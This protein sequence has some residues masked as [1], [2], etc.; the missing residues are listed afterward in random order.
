M[1][2]KFPIRILFF[3]S[4]MCGLTVYGQNGDISRFTDINGEHIISA[5]HRK[6]EL[7]VTCAHSVDKRSLFM[8]EN[9]VSGVKKK[10]F[11]TEYVEPSMFYTCSGYIVNDIEIDKD[12]NCWF[13][14]K[15]WTRT[16]QYIYNTN[17]MLEP[18]TTY[19]GYIGKF[20]M[21][22]VINGTGTI[23][24]MTVDNSFEFEHLALT[25]AGGIYATDNMLIYYMDPSGNGYDVSVGKISHPGA[26]GRF[27]DV[28]CLGDTVITLS[29]CV[30]SSH[31]FHYHDMFYLSYGE[32]NDFIN[33][34]NTYGYDVY[35]AYGDRRTR[36]WSDAPVFMTATHNGCGVVVSYITE[37]TD[38][39]EHDFPG[40][41]IMFHIPSENA[42]PSEIIHNDD[43][44]VYVKIKDIRSSDTSLGNQFMAV[45]LEDSYGNSSMR[46]PRIGTG[47]TDSQRDNKIPWGCSNESFGIWKID[48]WGEQGNGRRTNNF[49]ITPYSVFDS[50]T[51]FSP[52]K[53]S[54][55]DVATNDP[56]EGK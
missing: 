4:L 50:H 14:G 30:D 18:E 10:F 26:G 38:F 11:T 7:F 31:F 16:G 25:N 42:V 15:K 9:R 41:L 21:V 33:D 39:P 45:L 49:Y 43:T 20:N 34:D 48:Y 40:K 56:I 19:C 37:N 1:P 8:V 24:I 46:F 32:S 47:R 53:I 22:N 17:G 29:L 12:Y 52:Y 28:V 51:T 44:D 13:C 2:Y 3:A 54:A 27:M 36:R 35:Y 55:S 5:A 23:D 6:G